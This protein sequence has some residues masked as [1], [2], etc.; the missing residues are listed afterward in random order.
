MQ[1]DAD[2]LSVFTCTAFAST[3]TNQSNALLRPVHLRF[4]I[5]LKGDFYKKSIL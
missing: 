5:A 2:N 3:G 4:S 1:M